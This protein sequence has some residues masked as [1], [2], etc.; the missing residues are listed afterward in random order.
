MNDQNPR[1]GFMV[2]PD[3]TVEELLNEDGETDMWKVSGIYPALIA[4]DMPVSGG[5]PGDHWAQVL[6][7]S[8]SEH[9]AV[10]AYT[11]GVAPYEHP[12]PGEAVQPLLD[13][14]EREGR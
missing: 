10:T 4:N 11:A 1:R 6:D 13:W 12:I 3:D 8:L 7:F 9:G 2:W 14:L 5:N